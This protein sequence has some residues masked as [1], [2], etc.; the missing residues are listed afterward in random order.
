MLKQLLYGTVYIRVAKNQFL[1]RHI[2]DKKEVMISA[3]EPFTT[4]RLLIG[5]FVVAEK[6]LKQGINKVHEGR[7]LPA[8]PVVLIQP[9]EM[10]DGGLSQV[11]ERVLKELAAGAGAR[12]VV[13]WVGHELS[14]QEVVQ[15]AKNA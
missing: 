3:I 4:K 8:S 14:D 6:Y 12:K 7:W 9:L 2:E 1:V 10:I 15:R 5:E 13:V 11:E